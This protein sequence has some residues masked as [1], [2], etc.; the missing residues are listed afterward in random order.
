L[1]FNATG[2]EVLETLI[3]LS[4]GFKKALVAIKNSCFRGW[5][6]GIYSRVGGKYRRDRRRGKADGSP[7]GHGPGR[8]RL[9]HESRDKE[10]V[11]SITAGG[12]IAFSF[13][14]SNC[15]KS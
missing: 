13:W 6:E 3:S 2:V 5:L 12:R 14:T 8:G 4:A 9:E 15:G 1:D 10:I 11:G 7:P